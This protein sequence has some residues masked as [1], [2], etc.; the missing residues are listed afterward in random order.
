MIRKCRNR[1]RQ[2]NV[3]DEYV[4]AEHIREIL[5]QEQEQQIDSAAALDVSLLNLKTTFDDFRRLIPVGASRAI[6]TPRGH[7]TTHPRD[8]MASPPFIF[9][10]LANPAVPF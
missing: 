3:L 1:F 5:I 10:Y 2:H 9:S 6:L 7:F 8:K 4:V